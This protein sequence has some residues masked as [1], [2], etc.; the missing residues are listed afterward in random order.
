MSGLIAITAS[1]VQGIVVLATVLVVK[2][3]LYHIF[4]APRLARRKAW[5][6]E[7][8]TKHHLM[9]AE[10]EVEPEDA[11][12]ADDLHRA[13]RVRREDDLLDISAQNEARRRMWLPGIEWVESDAA[14]L[15]PDPEDVPG[16]VPAR[17]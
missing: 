16:A 10:D 2:V 17:G 11:G 7:L 1:L 3:Y 5:R 8:R 15:D 6:I 14:D 4:L 12:I 13:L 9:H